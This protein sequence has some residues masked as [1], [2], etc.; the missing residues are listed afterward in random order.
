MLPVPPEPSEPT[1]QNGKYRNNE[2]RNVSMIRMTT[3]S[4]SKM[5]KSKLL[6]DLTESY[7]YGSTEI[8]VETVSAHA[9]AR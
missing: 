9:M 7:L 6:K 5:Q 3:I 8:N 2:T 4:Q 1:K